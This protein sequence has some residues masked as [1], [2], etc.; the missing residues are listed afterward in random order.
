MNTVE[1]SLNT[2]SGVSASVNFATETV[3][4]LAPTEVRTADLIKKIKSAGYGAVLIEDGAGPALHGKRSGV[5]LFFAFIFA[6]PAIAVSMVHQWHERID[7][8][9]LLTLEYFDILP[10]LYSPTAWLAIGLTAPLI[11][12]VALPIHRAAIR[13]FFHPTMDSLISLG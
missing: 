8:E 1:K 6:V 9:I 13:N 3:H 5:A 4:V 7:L 10:P 12:I 11:L 2:M